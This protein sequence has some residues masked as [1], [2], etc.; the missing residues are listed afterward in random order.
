MILYTFFSILFFV[1]S[2]SIAYNIS[3]KINRDTNS[4]SGYDVFFLFSSTIPALIIHYDT[5]F[6]KIARFMFSYFNEEK[7]ILIYMAVAI[8]F[9]LILYLYLRISC[10]IGQFLFHLIKKEEIDEIIEDTLFDEIINNN[11]DT[12][13]DKN[14]KKKKNKRK[15][16]IVQNF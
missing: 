1:I 15:K 6:L 9:I 14:K 5:V 10:T 13:K 8:L 4:V 16:V 11:Y 2:I 12:K 3:K 7:V